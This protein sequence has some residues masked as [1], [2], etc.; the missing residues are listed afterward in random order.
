MLRGDLDAGA[1]FGDAWDASGTLPDLTG[2]RRSR[3]TQA[4]PPPTPFRGLVTP[5]I[6]L[7]RL[8]SA[9]HG[10]AMSA[11]PLLIVANA[12]VLLY[13]LALVL[14]VLVR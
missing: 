1:P 13:D 7:S 5:E 10:L 2:V 11:G 4:D 6:E 8:R 9:A 3:A 14:K 12:G